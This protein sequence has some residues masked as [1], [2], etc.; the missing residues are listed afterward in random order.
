[1]KESKEEKI[2][3]ELEKVIHKKTQAYKQIKKLMQLANMLVDTAVE[4]RM[5]LEIITTRN[6][7]R[8]RELIKILKEKE[9]RVAEDWIAGE[10]YE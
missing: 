7:K 4:N 3:K 10:S 9:P 6:L 8:R 5:R 1:M 2:L